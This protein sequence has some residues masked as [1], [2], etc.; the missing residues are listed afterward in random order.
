MTRGRDDNGSL[1]AERTVY[2]GASLRAV[3][4][5][6]GGIGA[7]EF[8]LGGDGLLRQ[9]QI[10]NQVN[11]TAFLPDTFF[12]IWAR[13][14]DRAAEPVARLLQT[15]CF[16]DEEFEPVLSASDHIIPP[17][18]ISRIKRL[19]A[20]GERV[21]VD[22]IRYVGE[23]PIAELEY[24]DEE[25]PVEVSLEA[26]SPMIP[27][28]AKDSGLPAVV[29]NFTVRNTTDG[30]T[31]V[32]LMGTLQNAVGYDAGSG[33][34][35][36]RCVC[37]GGNRNE[38]V[39]GEGLAAVS[40][41]NDR[42]GSDH[43]GW[44]SM[45]I[46]TLGDEAQVLE[47]W[48][49]LEALWQRFAVD[50]LVGPSLAAG[51]SAPG[52]THNG[53]VAVRFTL[54]PGEERVIPIVIAWH[55]PNHYVNWNQTGFGVTDTKTK[56][57]LGNMYSN[58][59]TSALDAAEYVGENYERLCGDTRLYRDTFYDSTL[60]YGLLD[61]VTSQTS[62]IRTPT[63]IWNADGNFHGFEGAVGAVQ[64]V[65]G[66]SSG[67]CPLNCTHVWNY[68]MT[69]SRLFPDL[70]R[71]MRATDWHV[72]QTD[73]GGVIFRTVV[74]LY[75]PRWQQV[76]AGERTT[77][78]CDGHWGTVLKTYRE[79][80]QSGS[81][82]WL[83]EVWP[84]VQRAMQYG[85]ETWDDDEDGVLDGPQWNTFDLY[86]HGHNTYC[87]SLYLAALRA[88]EEM[89]KIQGD[90]D[91]ADDCRRRF[92]SGSEKIDATLFNGEYYEQHFDE[93]IEGADHHQYGKGCI[94][95]QVFGQWWA[96][97]LGLGYILDPEKV[98]SALASVHKYN[99]R[100]N[101]IGHTQTPRV[102]ASDW[103]PSLLNASWPNG[104]RQ[105]HPML[106]CDE[107]WTSIEYHLGSHMIIEGMI[108]QGMELV[109]AAR[110][111]HNGVTRNPWNE[112]EC[113][114]HYV[115]PMASWAL[116]EGAGGRVYD[117]WRG[118]ISFDPR[119]TPEQFR[120]FFIT[121]EGWGTFAQTRD[122]NSQTNLLVVAWGELALRELRLGLAE[123]VEPAS[124]NVRGEDAT[125]RLEDGAVVLDLGETKLAAGDELI[126]E[127]EW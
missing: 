83:D 112:I 107:V 82:D 70:E 3:A 115:R 4:M 77:I 34:A 45:V 33:I 28:N 48:Q 36:N 30:P 84:N 108:E 97:S 62:T 118:M 19:E 95:D 10:F 67:S 7:G 88:C 98:R 12:A 109:Q 18:A 122:G 80:Q 66:V 101:L 78:A 26:L 53:A 20:G 17:E 13:E 2:S 46:A 111:R 29:F 120:S 50:G 123:G 113:G 42:L 25:L 44:G 74:P 15:D 63:C 35:G 94:S 49:D 65:W 21:C 81:K 31:Q 110:N 92:E 127:I 100:Q 9:W 90:E 47:R 16:Y 91:L 40:M 102:Y 56:F 23:Y 99:F 1:Q 103:E 38:A 32:S 61:A 73:E 64:G 93:S 125:W 39:C 52:E 105:E 75:L 22:D 87:S 89:A 106:Y 104:G 60:P 59:F 96:H 69:L 124:V 79:F 76:Q 43:A 117:A 11:H 126:V 119:T 24:V 121:A 58:W 5:P 72:Q 68:E 51:E 114:D 41:T 55:F 37:Y 14:G 57:H 8:A 6:M 116:L 86:F 71:T 27:L 54:G 85:F